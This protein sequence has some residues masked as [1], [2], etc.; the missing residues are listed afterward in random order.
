MTE[1]NPKTGEMAAEIMKRVDRPHKEREIWFHLK[2]KDRQTGVAL[3][4]GIYRSKSLP[5]EAWTYII[6]RQV[7]DIIDG[8]PTTRWER[9]I[10]TDTE[11]LEYL[12]KQLQY[13]KRFAPISGKKRGEKT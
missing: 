7:V 9:A 12:G 5:N 6:D 3:E 1:V 13:L 11:M 10:M 4:A 8:K 2:N